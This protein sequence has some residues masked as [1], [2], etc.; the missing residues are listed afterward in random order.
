M[1]INHL[2]PSWDGP[3]NWSFA[4][5]RIGGNHTT[6][7]V[8]WVSSS[9]QAVARPKRELWQISSVGP[10]GEH[11][12]VWQICLSKWKS[13]PG[14]KIKYQKPPPRI[15][16]FSHGH[17]SGVMKS[18]KMSLVS[19]F[20]LFYEFFPLR[21]P[22]EKDELFKEHLFTHQNRWSFVSPNFLLEKKQT[23]GIAGRAVPNQQRNSTS[24]RFKSIT[25][26]PKQQLNKLM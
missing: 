9:T 4:G 18:W 8:E 11:Q 20:G 19:K 10:V 23:L 25:T 14:V 26:N 7:W 12:P 2:R 15:Y 1:V 22:L 21:W 24:G 16:P 13:S 6:E 3:P 17:G 5:W